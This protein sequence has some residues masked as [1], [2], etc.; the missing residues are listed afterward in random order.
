MVEI[1][2]LLSNISQAV[3]PT[4]W[5]QLSVMVPAVLSMTGEVTMLNISRWTGKGGNYP[6]ICRLYNAPLVW[7]KIN[8]SLSCH[9]LKEVGESS[10]W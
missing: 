9:K 3:S 4:E 5:R 2:A 6:T 8:W 1:I 7:L 10:C